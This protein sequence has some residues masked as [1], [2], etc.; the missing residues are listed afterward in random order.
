MM[1]RWCCLVV[2]AAIALA[3]VSAEDV[4]VQML[5][6]VEA[7]PA[8]GA[9]NK[10]LAALEK[11]A[12]AK[13]AA[14]AAKK[15]AAHLAKRKAAYQKRL[16]AAV[17]AARKANGGKALSAAKKKELAAKTQAKM[18]KM[19]TGAEKAVKEAAN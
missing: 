11:N 13:A 3:A 2:V 1:S 5:S 18:P 10:G 12:A 7:K 6:E 17:A 19:K 14:A 9:L 8:G 16:A 15:A 4:S